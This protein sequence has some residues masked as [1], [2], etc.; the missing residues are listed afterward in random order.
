MLYL[1][2]KSLIVYRIVVEQGEACFQQ[3]GFDFVDLGL[4]A[5][6]QLQLE[7]AA[8]DRH[9]DIAAVML[10][11]DNVGTTVAHDFADLA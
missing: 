9:V 2:K 11:T 5:G 1:A 3:L 4:I 8:G 6:F 7:V 10:H